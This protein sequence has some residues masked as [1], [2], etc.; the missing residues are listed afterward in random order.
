MSKNVGRSRGKCGSLSSRGLSEGGCGVPLLFE[1]TAVSQGSGVRGAWDAG[2]A[3]V[4]AGE[5]GEVLG[6]GG[7][8]EGVLDEGAEVGL[9]DGVLLGG[10]LVDGPVEFAGGL[11]DAVSLEEGELLGDLGLRL[12]K[13]GLHVA[14]AKGAV[15][16]EVE[17]AQARFVGEALV[18][19]E[20]IHGVESLAWS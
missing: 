18:D 19:W 3:G 11:E 9:Q 14:D 16:Q 4:D 6:E 7:L 17:D 1:E 12:L 5:A 15:E 2:D 13:G 10:D 8:G 20:A